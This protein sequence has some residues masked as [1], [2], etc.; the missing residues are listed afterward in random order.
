MLSQES[1]ERYR[2]MTTGERLLLTLKMTGEALPHLL[3]GPP[4]V[5]KRRLEL[6]QRENDLRNQNMLRAIA[7]TRKSDG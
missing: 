4:E 6:L 7:R 1:I 3:A 5:V 2:N